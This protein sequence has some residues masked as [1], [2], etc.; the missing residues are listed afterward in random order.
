MK[1]PALQGLPRPASGIFNRLEC[2]AEKTVCAQKKNPHNG[3][4][5]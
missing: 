5:Q 3:R 1:R 4:D 2:T